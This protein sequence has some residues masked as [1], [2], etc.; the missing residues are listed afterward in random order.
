MSDSSQPRKR[1]FQAPSPLKPGTAELWLV[2][3]NVGDTYA[4]LPFFGISWLLEQIWR[5]DALNRPDAAWQGILSSVLGN[6]ILAKTLNGS[7]PDVAVYAW[8]IFRNAYA[9]LPELI[10]NGNNVDAVQAVMAMVLFIRQSA[11]TRTISHLIS[12][13]VRMQHLVAYRPVGPGSI[14]AENKARL[15]WTLFILDMDIAMNTGLPPSH[16]SLPTADFETESEKDTIFCLRFTLAQIQHRLIPLLTSSD[17][18]LL[19]NLQA[20]LENWRVSVPPP[21]RPEHPDDLNPAEP[22]EAPSVHLLG[23]HLAYHTTNNHLLWTLIQHLSALHYSS[24]PTLNALTHTYKI[25]VRATARTI[26][27][28]TPRLPITLP[29]LWP[30]LHHALS[31]AIILLTVI[32]KEP[33]HPEARHDISILRS[34]VAFLNKAITSGCALFKLRDGISRF[35]TVA[36]GAV[37]VAEKETMPVNPALWPLRVANGET[38]KTHNKMHFNLITALALLGATFAEPIPKPELLP[39]AGAVL[40]KRAD[41]W[42]YVVTNVNCRK[43][44]GT[45]YDEVKVEGRGYISPEKNFGVRCTKEGT[46]VNGDKTWPSSTKQS[47]Y[48]RPTSSSHAK[49]SHPEAKRSTASLS[50][51]EPTSH[52][53]AGRLL[54]NE[55]IFGQDSDVF[56]PERW[57]SVDDERRKE[58]E[59]VTELLF[60]YGR[61][62]CPGKQIAFLELSK[63]IFEL[64]RDFDFQII[65]PKTPWFFNLG[66]GEVGVIRNGGGNVRHAFRDITIIDHLF[67]LEE[68]AIIH[69]TDCGTLTFTEEQLRTGLKNRVDKVHWGDIDKMVFGANSG[70]EESVRQEV[71]WVRA[72]SLVS[73]KLK[74]GVQGF[75]FDLQSGKMEK[76]DVQ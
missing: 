26:L 9:V 70:L 74:R 49:K 65:N 64:F 40:D 27:S 5:P 52:K 12:V 2:E 47:G 14:D 4:E 7:F 45:N 69:H 11:D 42:C 72:H 39:A 6:T 1:V 60:G 22:P 71:E 20:E 54:R 36:E 55:E 73:E 10:L 24:L 67:G 23:L 41:N 8:S 53:I 25:T 30:A 35:I 63:L 51:E 16:A 29:T 34:L 18:S 13:A 28:L 17:E 43:G 57:L 21:F 62:Q 66:V 46:N 50:Q 15:S 38:A 48:T 33:T 3:Q 58:M 68:L 76:V 37:S 19:L 59:R 61:W 31:A 32:C 56:R 75:V 44:P